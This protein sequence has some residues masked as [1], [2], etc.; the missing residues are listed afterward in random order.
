[1][2]ESEQHRLPVD[3]RGFP[4]ESTNAAH[5]TN[6]LSSGYRSKF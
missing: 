5:K 6:A 4:Q 3:I 2:M 1:M